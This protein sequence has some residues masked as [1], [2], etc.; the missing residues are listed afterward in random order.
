MKFTPTTL[1]DAYL[2][3]IEAREDDRGFFARRF[4]KD[5]FAEV[6]LETEYVQHNYSFNHKRGTLRGMH[7]QNAPHREVKVVSC[8][9]GAIHDVIV[10]MRPDSPT[11]LKWEGF[12]LTADNHRQLY[13]PE[14]FAHGYITLTDNAAVAYLVSSVYAPGAEGG[15]RWNDPAIG[16]EWPEAMQEI[17][18]K[19]ANWGDFT[20][21]W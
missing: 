14:G 16:I 17:S 21:R 11:Y 15:L 10:D 1:Q 7:F 18:D 20:P 8:V 3:D 13:V 19:D 2:I 12:D 5:E 9:A 6:G 4:C